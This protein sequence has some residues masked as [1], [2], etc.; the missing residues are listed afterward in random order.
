M[1]ICTRLWILMLIIL[2]SGC[3]EQNN[4]TNSAQPNPS[5]PYVETM[6]NIVERNGQIKNKER[7]DEFLSN[8][9]QGEADRIRVVK[10]TTEGAAILY[11]YEF[12][13][14]VINVVIDTTRD[15]YGQ[16][17]IIQTACT[18]IKSVEEQGSKS[19]ELDGCTPSTG[20]RLILTIE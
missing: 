14:D 7:F 9:Q 3:G 16:Q 20:G 15:G 6:D 4:R 5:S 10:Y 12:K 11:D 17:Q 1:K 8:V 2:V 13:N 19:Y 18:S